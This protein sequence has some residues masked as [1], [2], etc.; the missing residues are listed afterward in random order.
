MSSEIRIEEQE[1]VPLLSVREMIQNTRI[2]SKMGEMFG[3][4]WMFMEK[5]KIEVAGPPFA[6]Y[7]D[8]DQENYDMECGFP[9]TRPE[10]GEGKMISSSVPGGKCVTTVHVGPYENIMV[11]YEKVQDY[12]R[13]E[14]LKPKKIMWERYL[15]DPATVKDPTQLVTE[16]YW[17]ID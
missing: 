2:K 13:K 5:N 1:P 14:G 8:Y 12:M 10:S 15:N 7:H 17:P 3:Q 9:T 11:T 6:V 4:I 16:I